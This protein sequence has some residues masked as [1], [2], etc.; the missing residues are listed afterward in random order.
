MENLNFEIRK[1][2]LDDYNMLY[3]FYEKI[4]PA[5]HPLKN[6]DFWKW[7]YGDENHGSAF[8]VIANNEIYGHIGASFS[9]GIAWIINV[10]L[11]EETRGKGF[12]S[13]MYQ[14]AR[15]MYEKLAA[16]SANDA[17]LGLYRNM[18]WIRY[19]NLE[20]YTIRHPELLGS[21][22]NLVFKE[23][24]KFSLNKPEDNFYWLQ[25]GINGHILSDGSTGFVQFD[26][27]GFRFV[28]L[29]DPDTA[30]SELWNLGIRWCDYV[31]SWNDLLLTDL[32][33][34]RWQNQKKSNFPWYL[35]PIDI[36]KEFNVTFLSE[37]PIDNNFICRRYNSDH[38]RVGSLPNKLN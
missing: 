16:T 37:K 26:N 32:E 18:R 24:V 1:A 23:I 9:D 22:I 10:Y 30:L 35:N 6:I 31:S 28:K 4:Y 29:C 27:G 13:I 11:M 14:M 36:T 8:I 12:L 33:R 15:E 7:Q 17:G 21:D 5:M 3:N 2:V 19:S 34:K 20:R 38:G 25:P